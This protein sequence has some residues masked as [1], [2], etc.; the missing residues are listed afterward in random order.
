MNLETK[1]LKELKEKLA[2]PRKIALI[3]HTRP[4]GD[5]IGS[6]LGLAH[7]LTAKGHEVSSI[8]PSE[9]PEFISWLPGADN[10]ICY[11]EDTADICDEVIED[12]ELLFC[13]D[14]S[15]LG[16][17]GAMTEMITNR[18][19]EY[20]MMDH[21]LD[22]EDFDDYRYWSSDAA[23]TAE[24]VYCFIKECGDLDLITSGIG[25]CLYTGILTD[26]GSFRHSNTTPQ[27][28]AIVSDLIARGA[29]NTKIHRNIYDNNSIERLKLL[30]TTLSKGLE[31]IKNS[32]TAYVIIDEKI[33]KE[34][35]IKSGDTEGL[36]NYALSLSGILFAVMIKWSPEY[37]K[38]SLR[39][40]GE[41]PANEIAGKYFNGGGHRNASGGRF[42]GSVE[43]TL[44]QLKIAVEENKDLLEQSAK[45]LWKAYI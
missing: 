35:D 25:E 23:A 45:E 15:G 38:L 13:L 22:P 20:V 26:T 6:M 5:A 44:A 32:Y 7:Y 11:S 4:D 14:F 34:F 16:R 27:V 8:A 9:F 31:V 10:V 39:S 36:V 40:K 1:K 43:E 18:N 21:H 2:E 24:L 28:H 33:H 12:S 17:V 37:T 19:C 29:D 3:C 30:G 42:D 41:F